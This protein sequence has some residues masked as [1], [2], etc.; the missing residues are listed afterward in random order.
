VP[1]GQ[2]DVAAAEAAPE[3]PSAARI[4]ERHREIHDALARRLTI[5]AISR[6]LRLDRKTV[7]RYATAPT[8][9]ELIPD[10]PLT[11]PGLLDPHL[12]YLHQRWADGVRSTQRLHQE[13][14]ARGYTGSLRTL[15]RRT[16]R[17]RQDTTT[18][19]P[20]PAPAAKKVARWIHP[21]RRPQRPRPR[22]AGADH[23]T[24]RRTGATQTLF[25]EFA[26]MLA[27]V[28]LHGFARKMVPE[29]RAV[30]LPSRTAQ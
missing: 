20:P 21:A 28:R 7:R 19:A 5:T 23:R 29:K 15:C 9:A 26:A 10:A 22:R 6:T 8:S 25:R 11:R 2:V 16:A 18:P 14:R 3:R 17:L 1:R 27:V 30:N 4:R 13:L 12:P 24:L